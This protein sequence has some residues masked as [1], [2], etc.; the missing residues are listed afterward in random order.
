MWFVT[1]SL[2]GW[3]MWNW[4]TKWGY[5]PTL[6]DYVHLNMNNFVMGCDWIWSWWSRT[7]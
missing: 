3:R 1:A 7:L 5:W 6:L 4:L 2:L